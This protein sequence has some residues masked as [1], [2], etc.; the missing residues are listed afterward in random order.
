MRA[1]E[2]VFLT[3]VHL[4][5]MWH[6]FVDFQFA[7]CVHWHSR[8]FSRISFF[9]LMAAGLTTRH[10]TTYDKTHNKR[11]RRTTADLTLLIVL[12]KE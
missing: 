2:A 4:L 5:F 8:D 11:R 7:D 1:Y 3:P 6:V 12:A 10:M 9:D